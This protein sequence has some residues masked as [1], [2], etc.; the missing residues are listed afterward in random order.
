[1]SEENNNELSNPLVPQR[2]QFQSAAEIAA[3]TAVVPGFGSLAGFE[4]MQ[5]VAKVFAVSVLVPKEY[6]G[7]LGNCCIALEL[8]GRIG[9]SPLM[10]MQNLYIVHGK[11][12]WSSQFLIAAVN[13]CG[14]YHGLKYKFSG[15]KGQDDYA[16]YAYTT[17]RGTNELVR[18]P[19][20]TLKMA[21]EKGWWGRKDS[22]WPAQTDLM[23]HYRAATYFARTNAPELTMGI[24]TKDELDDTGPVLQSRMFEGLES[25]AGAQPEP[26]AT[27]SPS[28]SPSPTPA[29]TRGAGAAAKAAKDAADSAK[30]AGSNAGSEGAEQGTQTAAQGTAGGQES[31]KAAAPVAGHG[32]A[33]QNAPQTASPPAGVSV[34]C[35]LNGIMWSKAQKGWVDRMLSE[36]PMTRSITVLEALDVLP[37]D[38]GVALE[39]WVNAL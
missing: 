34:D 2:A 7:N 28:P 20:V 29:R 3:A 15:T 10:V 25:K 11:P 17:E 27:P 23:M 21:K 32:K 19:E 36:D 35:D 37:A 18:G 6:Q 5:R 33:P 24:Q 12:A 9:A 26:S 38:E 4:L 30:N 39:A 22:N 13:S 14:R 1:M 31:D 8:A 16:C